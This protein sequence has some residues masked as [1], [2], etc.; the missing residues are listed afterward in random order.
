MGLHHADI[1]DRDQPLDAHLSRFWVDG[2]LSSTTGAKNKGLGR[3]LPTEWFLQ[4]IRD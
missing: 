4:D 3:D 2:H 1:V